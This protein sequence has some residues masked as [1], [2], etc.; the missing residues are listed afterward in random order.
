MVELEGVGARLRG[1]F[2]PSLSFVVA[3]LLEVL[4]VDGCSTSSPS[5]VEEV[6]FITFFGL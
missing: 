4:D 2:L 6:D 3:L 5:L 1:R